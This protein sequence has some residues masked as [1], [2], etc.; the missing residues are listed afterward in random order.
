MEKKGRLEQGFYGA[1]NFW[2]TIK[3]LVCTFIGID[4]LP[5]VQRAMS[6]NWAYRY[7]VGSIYHYQ[8]QN[9]QHT[10]KEI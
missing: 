1:F 2:P 9:N 3:F 8:T 5:F 4:D 10:V 6:V 7:W